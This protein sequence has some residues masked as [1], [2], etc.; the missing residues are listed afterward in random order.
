MECSVFMDNCWLC[1]AVEA[2]DTPVDKA[3]C[4]PNSKVHQV[5]LMDMEVQWEGLLEEPCIPE[6]KIHFAIR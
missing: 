1:T 5:D 4:S 3:K 6:R 2:V